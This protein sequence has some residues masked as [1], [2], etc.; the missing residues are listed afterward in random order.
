M[1]YGNRDG[2][3]DYLVIGGGFYGCCLSLFLRTVSARVLL[4]EAE[5]I[6]MGRASRV[7][8]ARIH[9]GFH[10]PR[11]ALTAVRSMVLHR[12]FISDFPDAVVANFQM[13]YAIAR[14]RSKV[15][16][17]RFYRMF[18]D[19][20][21]PI[22]AAS[23]VQTALFDSSTVEGVFACEEAAFDYT[24]LQKQLTERL[25]QAG[26]EVLLGTRVNA[27]GEQAARVIAGLSDGR[28]ITARHVFNITYS[29]I[30]AM[31]DLA[32]L[33][34][35][36]LKHELAEV[37]LVEPPEHLAN[38][39][40]TLMDGPF[41]SCM[42]YPSEQLHS[43]THVRYTPHE[44]WIDGQPVKGEIL[45]GKEHRPE[46]HVRHMILDGSRFLP[47]LSEVRHVKSL[48]EVKTILRKN[49]HDDGRPI[50]YQRL[51]PRSRIVSILGAKIDNIY[52]LFELVQQTT[53]ELATASD[54]LVMGRKR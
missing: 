26:V 21:A 42:P 44:S 49:E 13:L 36:S 28:E 51:P 45:S 4:V 48:Y 9:T 38:I 2:Y 3:Y 35:A 7:N 27:L 41:F 54:D 5:D 43:L 8:Q 46:T 10:Y 53:P 23:T 16:S 50:L 20:G 33:P 25:A 18:R 39:G 1:Q 22:R 31:L 52:D 29:K 15:S 37:A 24:V 30:N 32:G 47:S 14:N 40:I 11:S 34:H 6:L 19:L 17:L 12:R